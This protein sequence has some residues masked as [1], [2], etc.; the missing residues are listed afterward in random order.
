M[1]GRWKRAAP[2]NDI[3]FDLRRMAL[4][5]VAAGLA[6]PNAEHPE[7]AG[8]VVDIRCDGA[9]AT[10]VALTDNATS[11]Y[12]SSGGGTIGA[13]EHPHVAAA[14]QRLLAEVQAHLDL[15]DHKD[16]GTLPPRGAVRLHVL[17]PTTVRRA[18]V[19]DKVFWGE[20]EH[21]LTPV[22]TKVQDVI[23]AMRTATPS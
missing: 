14:T 11:M 2:H 1:F 9:F 19:S 13:G 10:V 12:T 7:V 20:A 15:F 16:D 5:A 8:L 6:P 3:Y 21:A 22:I 17:T 4:G 23:S 18:D